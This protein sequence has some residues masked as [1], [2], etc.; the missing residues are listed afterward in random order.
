M[1]G[2]ASRFRFTLGSLLL[3]PLLVSPIL[4]SRMFFRDALN[5]NEGVRGAFTF[6]N[7]LALA[8][9]YAAIFTACSG[10]R[11][12]RHSRGS[13][14]VLPSAWKGAGYGAFFMAQIAI[15]F[16]IALAIKGNKQPG[17]SM[18]LPNLIRLVAGGGIML[19]LGAVLG[20]FAGVLIGLAR[21]W[22]LSRTGRVKGAP[23]SLSP[24]AGDEAPPALS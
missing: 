4:L 22:R 20:A 15:P 3:L 18:Y 12:R 23:E 11:L 21:E 14:H 24:E 2:T 1:P 7:M 13:R 5:P 8:M 9:I 19:T 6:L 16:L 10:R 17:A